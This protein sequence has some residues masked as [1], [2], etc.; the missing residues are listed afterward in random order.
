MPTETFFQKLLRYT[1]IGVALALAAF[2][3]YYILGILPVR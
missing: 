2:A 1:A 3:M